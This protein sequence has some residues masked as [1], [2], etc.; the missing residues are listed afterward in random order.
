MLCIAIPHTSLSGAI[1]KGWTQE[2]VS[3]G[4][5]GMGRD[6]CVLPLLSLRACWSKLQRSSSSAE[7]CTGKA[8]PEL[9]R[10]AVCAWHELGT[11]QLMWSLKRSYKAC[12]PGSGCG[13]GI[14]VMLEKA[15]LLQAVSFKVQ[16][17]AALLAANRYHWSCRIYFY[18]YF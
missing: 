18:F 12:G 13:V 15:L 10:A 2:W 4:V 6:V 5:S 1:P 8:L 7:V 14:W 9:D 16:C 3:T 11:V 17:K